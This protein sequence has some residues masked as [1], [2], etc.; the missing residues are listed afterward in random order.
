MYRQIVISLALGMMATVA[1]NT[2]ASSAETAFAYKTSYRDVA[3]DPDG[4]WTGDALAAGSAGKV[5]IYEYELR[6]NQGD[7]LISQIWN[8]D[9]SSGACPTRLV[10]IVPNR[11]PEILV[12]DMMHQ[13]I[14][15]DDPRFA[16]LSSG[17]AQAA[18]AR[19]PFALAKDG[20]TLINGDFKFPI[21]GDQP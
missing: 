17:S 7:L 5:T 10:R 8:E 9:C 1:G 3:Q 6:R 16:A 11:A 12:D 18:F 21:T 4:I 14:P 19:A 13:V 2:S 20:R 15:P